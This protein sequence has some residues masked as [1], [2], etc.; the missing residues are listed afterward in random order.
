MRASIKGICRGE[1]LVFI[2][3]HLSSDASSRGCSV[4]LLG[5]GN[6]EMPFYCFDLDKH[7]VS[8]PCA[9]NGEPGLVV[10]Q[11]AVNLAVVAPFL[12]E[13]SL[14]L[15]FEFE[16]RVQT[17]KLSANAIKWAS[18]LTYRFKPEVAAEIRDIE[19]RNEY[20]GINLVF[21][22]LL[23]AKNANLVVGSLW[24]LQ[25][26]ADSMLDFAL[27]DGRGRRL[28]VTPTFLSD[29][30]RQA[31]FSDS[32]Q[33]RSRRFSFLIP[34][35]VS[36]GFTLM[37][38]DRF[39]TDHY[40]FLS[41]DGDCF[42]TLVEKGIEEYR[43]ASWDPAYSSWFMRTRTSE[44]ILAEQRKASFGGGAKFSIIVPLCQTLLPLFDS[45][46]S[47]VLNQT[48]ENWELVLVN[49]SPDDAGL[50]AAVT[51]LCGADNRVSVISLDENLGNTA[52]TKKGIAASSGDY[53][54]LLDHEDCLEP[55]ALFEYAKA[56]RDNGSADLIYCDEDKTD[57][58]GRL[59]FNPA[60]KPDFDPEL[61]KAYN[62]VA[63][64]LCISRFV[65]D[66][67][68]CTDDIDDGALDYYLALKAGELAR[69]VV[70]LPKVLY[71]QRVNGGSA[72][73]EAGMDL[74][75]MSYSDKAGRRAVEQALRFSRPQA[76]V[77][78]TAWPCVYKVRYA[79]EGT[80]SIS[81]IIPNKDQPEMLERCVRSII[82]KTSYSNYEIVIV[83]N[84]S[85]LAEIEACYAQLEK[86]DSRVRVI[87][88][89]DEF[90]FSKIVNYGAGHSSGE[91]LLLL[92][93][94]TEVIAPDWIE[95][96]LGQCQRA[97]VG[98]VGAKLY[99]EDDTIQ[100]A[101]VVFIDDYLWADHAYCG[102]T[103]ECWR[104]VN[105]SEIACQRVAVTGA[106]LMV[107]RDDFE[108]VS[109]FDEDLVVAFNDVDFYMKLRSVGLRVVYEPK[110][111]L[112]HYESVSR[113]YD[114]ASNYRRRRALKEKAI[115][116]S[117]W[118]EDYPEG[119]PFFNPNTST[120]LFHLN[121]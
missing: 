111:K 12:I 54:C 108:K 62:Y 2:K 68:D 45:M 15:R 32:S 19:K 97:E 40:G 21:H 81:I 99:Y 37:V 85:Q 44:T 11:G 93:N 42:N 112:Y 64:F 17:I 116:Y 80:P 27:Y 118:F 58:A 29:E 4:S 107:S 20:H 30:A 56:I 120:Y 65:I 26:E 103:D 3:V 38:R 82:E 75:T 89:E 5:D 53:I 25:D 35:N 83:E 7:D 34:Q 36:G 79:L 1:G 48:Y 55:D 106:C 22:Y 50:N 14:V 110:A 46:V 10:T 109:G 87:R 43:D 88:W 102:L 73:K 8:F 18:R 77:E 41:A 63:H 91:Y 95:A 69:S 59:F 6:I 98:A 96:M 61:L 100:H 51:E 76:L 57:E 101:G 39:S 117:K 66:Q 114:G 74:A 31:D 90:N 60:F 86:A 9:E 47:S 94:D 33:I 121:C 52:N 92:N 24:Y 115:L 71:H 13:G 67:I 104:G 70:H 72:A 49:A 16:G 78:N 113:G 84:N 23:P 119:D 28:E 105:K